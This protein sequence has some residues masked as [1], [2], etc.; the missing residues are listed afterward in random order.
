MVV[1]EGTVRAEKGYLRETGN[2]AF[3]IS[4]LVLLVALAMGSLFGYRGNTIVIE[5]EGSRTR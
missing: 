5:G 3:H 1:D 2:L 4:L